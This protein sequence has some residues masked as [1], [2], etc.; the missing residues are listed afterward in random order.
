MLSGNTGR[1]DGNGRGDRAPGTSGMEMLF[2]IPRIKY[3]Q[4]VFIKTDL[5]PVSLYWYSDPCNYGK[6][7]RFNMELSDLSLLSNIQRFL[8]LCTE[9]TIVLLLSV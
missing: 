5:N 6:K 3:C 4:E 2:F 9:Q 8:S 1:G 7:E